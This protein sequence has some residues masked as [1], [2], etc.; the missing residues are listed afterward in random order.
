MI[1]MSNH[2][3]EIKLQTDHKLVEVSVGGKLV[4]ELIILFFVVD[5]FKAELLA[6]LAVSRYIS[7][8]GL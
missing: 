7:Y 5:F 3:L 4:W 6:A 1:Y 2:N 8:F